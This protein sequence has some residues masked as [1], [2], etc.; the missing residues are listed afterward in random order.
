MCHRLVKGLGC[1]SANPGAMAEALH[2]LLPL[3]GGAAA[4]NAADGEGK[5]PLAALSDLRLHDDAHFKQAA[6][7]VHALLA[8]GADLQAP[9]GAKSG[10][11]GSQRTL[12]EQLLLAALPPRHPAEWDAGALGGGGGCAHN[13]RL[14][15]GW[16]RQ[17]GAN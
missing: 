9:Q 5:T 11:L 1:Q 17:L 2:V 10:V 13:E 3:A 6:A 14:A 15:S 12:P 7:S 16:R 8:A 4:L